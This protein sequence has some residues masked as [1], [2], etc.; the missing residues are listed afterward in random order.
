M[1]LARVR[2]LEHDVARALVGKPEAIR[3]AVIGLPARS[4]LPIDAALTTTET[5][6]VEACLAAL[7]RA[8]V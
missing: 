7:E 5:A 4:Q 8:G 1:T 3:L 6:E 2:R